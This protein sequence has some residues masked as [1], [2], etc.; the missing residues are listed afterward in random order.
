MELESLGMEAVNT[1]TDVPFDLK[2]HPWVV[3]CEE[4]TFGSGDTSYVVRFD[5][6]IL[7][8]TILH[9]GRYEVFE[10]WID[11]VPPS[12]AFFLSDD[13]CRRLNLGRLALSA[14]VREVD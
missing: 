2:N 8:E 10:I 12:W 5:K 3:D 4:V 13:A 1:T 9:N 6:P 7:P 11:T 14:L